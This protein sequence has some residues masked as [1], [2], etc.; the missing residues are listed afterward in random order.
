MNLRRIIALAL[1]LTTLCCIVQATTLT[2]TARDEFDQT[3]VE[4]ASVYINGAY[5]GSTNSDGQYTYSHSFSDSLRVGVEKS[6]YKYLNDLISGSKTSFFA[7]MKREKGILSINV[8][9]ADTLEALSGAVVKIS[10]TG[11]DDS[12]ATDSSGEAVFEVPLQSV[13]VIEVQLPRYDTIQKTVEMDQST[14]KVD[15]LIKRND[16]IVFQVKEAENGLPLP[17]TSVYI[18]GILQGTTGSDGRLTAYIEHERTYDVR[19]QKD[20]YQVFEES[21]FFGSA[22]VIYPVTL[23]KSLYPITLSVY[24]SEK[25]PVEYAEIYIDADYFGK[26]DTY[27]RSGVTNLIAGK[28]SFEVRKTGYENWYNEYTIDGTDD[29]IIAVIE[30][31]KSDVTLFVEDRDH[32]AVPGAVVKS[33]N[34]TIG[35]TD[36]SGKIT[37]QLLSGQDY[38]FDVTCKGYKDAAVLKNVPKGSTEM[39]IV[40]TIEKEMDIVFIGGIALLIII[41]CAAVFFGLKRFSGLKKGGSKGRSGRKGGGTL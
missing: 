26:S 2:I 19:I 8:L 6:G 31:G 21:H 18:E 29:N 15:Y 23:S 10:G 28:H 36:S 37:T 40:L 11:T 27:G 32:K 13:Y 12:E 34:N 1:I 14:K 24:D 4:G 35:V 30:Y 17:G 16:I 39:E 9:D 25:R 33:D 20:E 41:V 38:T 7:E 5:I 3:P 22:E